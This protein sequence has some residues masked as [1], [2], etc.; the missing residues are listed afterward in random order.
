MKPLTQEL[1]D[2]LIEL[3]RGPG[4]T[5]H[6]PRKIVC[7]ELGNVGIG[8]VRLPNGLDA[9]CGKTGVEFLIVRRKSGGDA[10]EHG[11]RKTRHEHERRQS[12]HSAAEKTQH[13]PTTAS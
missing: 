10:H 4:I 12:K 5:F 7:I 13:Y 9:L 6:R 3:A 8:E 1:F 11:A 2:W